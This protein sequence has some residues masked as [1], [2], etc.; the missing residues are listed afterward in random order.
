MSIGKE[1]K[2]ARVA[3][4]PKQA[5]ETEIR[6]RWSWVEPCVWTDRML[7]ALE[8]G[9]KGRVWFSLSDKVYKTENLIAA[10]EKVRKNDG[11]GGVD[12]VTVEGFSRHQSAELEKLEQQIKSGEYVPQAIR[13]TYIPKPGSN[14]KRPLGIPTI[15]DRIVQ[16]AVVQV[17]EP[18]FE[19]SFADCSYGFRP[20]RG[21]K[22][23]L[24]V[25]EKQLKEG[26]LYI[27]DADIKGYFDNIP[28]ERLMSKVREQIADERVLK[29]IEQFLHQKVMEELRGWTPEK[30]TPQ[31]GVISPILAN[32]YL[33]DLDHQMIKAGYK[34]VRYADDFIVMCSTEQQA[35]DALQR[36]RVW[37][38]EAQL[39]L[40]PTKTRICNMTNIGESFEFLGYKFYHTKQGRIVPLARKKSIAKLY[41]SIRRKTKRGCSG[42]IGEISKSVN[43]SLKGWF[44]YFKHCRPSV[45][46]PIDSWVRM[47][48]RSILLT[49][50]KKSTKYGK[51]RDCHTRWPNSYFE[52]TGLF[53]LIQA[54]VAVCQSAQR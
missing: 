10:Y 6:K 24:R 27:V 40:H 8:Q 33:N 52:A 39:A 53:S 5:E 30:G 34:M 54:R 13:R 38:E 22:D 25:V 20:G 18:I 48:L 15:R 42:T 3:A 12:H 11:A 26:K 45:F 49:R 32:I 51:N 41:E 46:E 50:D 21:C 9:V 28:Q 14:E 2:S 35:E 4:M 17:I 29:L 44:E 31:G 16:A 36:I 23:A 47:R 1:T 7:T 19:K 37:M 43:R